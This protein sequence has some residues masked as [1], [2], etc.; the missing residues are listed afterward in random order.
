MAT[1][2]ERNE[3]PVKFAYFGKFLLGDLICLPDFP[4]YFPKRLFDCQVHLLQKELNR[5]GMDILLTLDN[6][7]FIKKELYHK[8]EFDWE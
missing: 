5:S 3:T 8:S 4:D 2:Q 1:F 7:T 6:N